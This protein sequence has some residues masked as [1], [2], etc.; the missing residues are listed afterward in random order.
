MIAKILEIKGA[1]FALRH[2]SY[3]EVK[4]RSMVLVRKVRSCIASHPD[5]KTVL[6][7]AFAGACHIATAKIG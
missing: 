4:P 6:E 7:D 5:I 3:A 1:H 2:T